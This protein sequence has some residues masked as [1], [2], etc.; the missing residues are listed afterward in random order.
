M[1]YVI[2]G[3]AGN[4]SKP[5]TEKLL[6]AGHQV[7]VIGRNEKNLESLTSKGATAA[8]GSVDDADFLSKTFTGADAVYTMIPPQYAIGS[9]DAYGKLAALYAEAIKTANVK[10]VINLSSVGADL[11]EGVGPVS[12]LHL[13]EKELEK[14]SGVNVLNIR[15]GFFYV[16][17]YGNVGMIK[18]AN[19]IGGNYG[20]ANAQMLL[21]HPNDIAE[22][23]AE[24][25]QKLDFEGHSVRY[26]VSDERT[27]GDVAKVLGAAIGKPELPWINFSDDDANAGLK[28]AGVPDGMADK[29]TEMGRAMRTGI[30]WKHYFGNRPKQL[31]KIKLEDFAKEFAAA[32]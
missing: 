29:Y 9:L 6:A 20:D 11:S 21:V 30:M 27:T 32:F 15:A 18:G 4:V 31:G 28:Q 19:I 24:E 13:V 10:Y 7:T 8:I 17:F 5:L 16:N 2:T 14:L 12:G 22:A 3:A 23:A 26:V 1:K 25:L